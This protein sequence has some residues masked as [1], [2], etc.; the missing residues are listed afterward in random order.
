MTVCPDAG[1]RPECSYTHYGGTIPGTSGTDADRRRPDAFYACE[2][3]FTMACFKD[4]TIIDLT[5]RE[6]LALPDFRGTTLRV[7]RGSVWITQQDDTQDIVLRAG[8]TWVVERNGL[9]LL[10]AQENSTLCVVGRQ[11]AASLTRSAPAPTRLAAIGRQARD[12]ATAFFTGPPRRCV[13]YA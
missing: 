8:D 11:V 3:R 4:G 1:G 2:R 9:T 10:E 13:P 6:N 12:L 5:A 7:T